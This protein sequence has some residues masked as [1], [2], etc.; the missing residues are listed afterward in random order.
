MRKFWIALLPALLLLQL[1]LPQIGMA[2]ASEVRLFL[3]GKQLKPEE[4]PRIVNE[5][6]LVPMRIISEALGAK[7]DWIQEKQKATVDKG[8]I[9]MDFHIN[10]LEANVNGTVQKLEAAPIN[11]NGNTLLPVRIVAEQLGLK[12]DWDNDARA[13]LLTK[14]E[15]EKK[16]EDGKGNGGENGQNLPDKPG[17]IGTPGSEAPGGGGQKPSGTAE[18]TAIGFAEDKLTILTNGNVKPSLFTLKNPDRLVIELPNSK[19]SKSLKAGTGIDTASA[20][21][22]AS[23]VSVA[24]VPSASAPPSG[25][26]T[27]RSAASGNP[28]SS[29]AAGTSPTSDS[30][31]RSIAT[32]PTPSPSPTGTAKATGSASPT[33]SPKDNAGGAGTQASTATAA[34]GLSSDSV[35]A[36]A[37]ANGGEFTP[38]H[39]AIGK[40]RYANFKNDPAVVRVVVDLNSK[41]FYNL[42]ESASAG[43]IVIAFSDKETAAPSPGS[44][45]KYKVVIDAGHGD[46]DPGAKSVTGRFEKDFTLAMALKVKKYLQQDSSI[47][48]LMTR[49]DD[50]FLELDERVEFANN[51]NADVF[52]SIHGNKFTSPSVRGTETY[53]WREQ[54]FELAKLLHDRILNAAG[55]PDRK[56]KKNDYR[57]IK[58][59]TMP[60]VLC[61]IGFLS[62]EAEE[63][64]MFKEELQEKVA[65]A[66]AAGIKQYLH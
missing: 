42:V 51:R 53:Y 62:N 40:I 27:I 55:F 50:T 7:V 54:S 46:G 13:V 34:G 52:V 45:A 41:I 6:T 60:A 57:V 17:P 15:P 4:P 64:Q 25:S 36:A 37:S 66:I 49:E 20:L 16:P 59:T 58:S 38:I 9:H 22:Q 23:G 1:L 31:K 65:E 11:V 18:V 28:E 44:G 48:V 24:E 32:S 5:I 39:K 10:R 8:E 2:N 63:A 3:D 33:P 47:E 61:E 43:A 14:K 29:S 35:Q 26:E 19:L 30:G 21:K 12:V 56:V